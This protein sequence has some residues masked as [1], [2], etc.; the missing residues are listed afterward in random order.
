MR[1]RGVDQLR[2]HVEV[3][4][5]ELVELAPALDLGDDLVLV[6]DRLQHAR[7]GG[8]AR[9]C[10]GA[11]CDSP[12]L[13]EQDLAELLRR[14]DRELRRRPGPRS[15][16][17]AWRPPRARA[18]RPRRGARCSAARPRPPSRAARATSGSSISSMQ[19]LQPAL[20]D[21]LALPRGQRA[22]EQRGVARRVVL[23]VGGQ[24]ALLAQLAERERRAARAR[25]GRRRAACRG[26]GWP[27]RRPATWRRG[28]RP[29]RSPSAQHDASGRSRVAGEHVL[30]D[31]GAEAPAS[32]R[33]AN[34]SPSG[35][36]RARARR[37][38]PPARR[39]ERARRRR[40][41]PSRRRALTVCSLDGRRRGARR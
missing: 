11:C 22:H 18:R 9:S 15:R 39:A 17:R 20:G 25:A 37:S 8:E 32:A 1:E 5:D 21:L 41:V 34:S 31:G 40:R 29:G 36:S 33:A 10:R 16:A 12:S 14:A 38:R 7:V 23:G 4:L 13:L 26:R 28:R 35:T 27:A 24:A 30:A 3:G 2:Q 19:Q 6:A